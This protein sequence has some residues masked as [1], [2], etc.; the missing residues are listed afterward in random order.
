MSRSSSVAIGRWLRKE[1]TETE[2]VAG[3]VQVVVITE[4]E[5]EDEAEE[6]GAEVTLW[7]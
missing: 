4:E 7:H 1:A 5:E 2:V 3:L 6:E